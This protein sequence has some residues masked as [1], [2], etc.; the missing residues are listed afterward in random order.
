MLSRTGWTLACA[1]AAAAGL[2]AVG[3]ATFSQGRPEAPR[4]AARPAGEVQAQ[5]V[6]T[7]RAVRDKLQKKVT[8]KYEQSPLEAVVEDLATQAGV[9]WWINHAA[10]EEEFIPLDEPVD[11]DLTD[12]TIETAL[13]II[14]DDAGITWYVDGDV[15]RITTQVNAGEVFVTRVYD[16]R[17]LLKAMRSRTDEGEIAWEETVPIQIGGLGGHVHQ[18]WPLGGRAHQVWPLYHVPS[19][20]MSD[21]V[22]EIVDAIEQTTSGPW[23][24]I[25]GIGGSMTPYGNALVVRQTHVMHDEV[26]ALLDALTQVATAV[27]TVEPRIVRPPS[28]P[29]QE[30]AAVRAALERRVDVEW[31][32]KPLHEALAELFKDSGVRHRFNRAAL[33]NE[34]IPIDSPIDLSQRNVPRRSVLELALPQLGLT[35]IVR[36]GFVVV[37]TETAAGDE[38]HAVVYDVR[39]LLIDDDFTALIDVIEN[40]TSG[41][42][43]APDGIGG[44][45]GRIPPRLLVIRADDH[46]HVEIERLLAL[47]REKGAAAPAEKPDPDEVITRH[48]QFSVLADGQEIAAAVREF[49]A[50]DSWEGAD[51]GSLRTVGNVLVVRHTRKVQKQVE[52]FLR[53]LAETSSPFGPA[54]LN[55][56]GLTGGGVGGLGGGFYDIGR[57]ARPFGSK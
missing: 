14:L 11:A 25:E 47:L 17:R 52:R 28:Y 27:P 4:G 20:T 32:A 24:N 31:Q 54:A 36:H 3:K 42:W 19:G 55:G 35:W 43:V 41:P 23:V 53:E 26:A 45:F 39:D 56:T 10:L 29:L 5:A 15:L 18:V 49:V 22:S 37:T 1:L 40:E 13:E 30:D 16:L 44:T 2:L 50:P 8:L 9:N 21:A 57:Q 34:N 51:G 6:A 7:E 12:V 38:F 33:E 48:H 46:N